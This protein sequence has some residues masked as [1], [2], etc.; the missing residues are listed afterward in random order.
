[1]AT[2]NQDWYDLN[3]GRSYPVADDATLIDSAGGRLPNHIICDLHILFPEL[4]GEYAY[5]GAVTVSSNLVSVIVMASPG[6]AGRSTVALAAVNLTKPITKY[7]HYPL[8][9]L[10]PGVGG[11]I[12]FGEG[13][14]ENYQG[15]FGR[16]SQSRLVE[17]TARKYPE[18]PIPNVGKA[19]NNSPLTGLVLLEAGND[20]EI[21][22]EC[23]EIPAHPVP[24]HSSY[25]CGGDELGTQVRDVI[26]FRLR[27]N[28]AEEENVFNKYK[29]RCGARPE[30]LSCG[31]PQPIQFLGPVSPD[32]CGNI[33]LELRGCMLASRVT[34]EDTDVACGVVVDCD[35]DIDEACVTAKYLPEEDGK[36][37][38]EYDDLCA[39]VSEIVEAPEGDF[40][41]L[42]DS[43][44]YTGAT[45]DLADR[46]LDGYGYPFG[47]AGGGEEWASTVPSNYQEHANDYV[48]VTGGPAVGVPAL[49]DFDIPNAS[50]VVSMTFG[51]LLFQNT[52]IGTPI[53]LDN[54]N[55]LKGTVTRL[56]V[57]T[58]V[59]QLWKLT[60]GV[61]AQIGG[62]TLLP[63]ELDNSNVYRLTTFYD[64]VNARIR[65]YEV[66]VGQADRLIESK[67]SVHG[68]D[69]TTYNKA[70]IYGWTAGALLVVR[71]HSFYA[72]LHEA[73]LDAQPIAA[74]PTLPKS[75]AIVG[76]WAI[77]Q[78]QF[79]WNA[80][81]FTSSSLAMTNLA[82]FEPAVPPVGT[83]GR[84]AETEFQILEGDAG[85]KHH[86]GVVINYRETSVGSGVY[87]FWLVDVDWD[88]IFT[89]FKSFRVARFT[90][91]QWITE[92]AVAV[93]GLALDNRYRLTV[94]VEQSDDGA[95]W[96]TGQL[97]GIDGPALDISIGPVRLTQY[98][99]DDDLFGI[100][101]QQ[102]ATEFQTFVV[103]NL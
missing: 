102:S 2:R 4:A 73:S 1:M 16:A 11:W 98:L 45:S 24:S 52:Y 20:M 94:S 69:L 27:S 38:T 72:G 41:W 65:L 91:Y 9:A 53:A 31:D 83:I 101:A 90:G 95:V 42:S 19:G 64:S 3:T 32:C 88:G 50:V 13:I 74:D 86:A 78:G 36:L 99:P 18:L 82:T 26:V 49:V 70:G 89:G 17:K 33:N 22:S 54:D 57:G 39:S 5:L 100:I 62:D 59:L 80:G 77:Q 28:T 25:Y 85:D 87:Q 79:T 51:T 97:E 6:V 75:P 71:V 103:D 29:G 8:E 63:E 61:W 60:A 46:I 58:D 84:F 81:V 67:D 76:D 30:S 12:V 21:V 43:F 96:V 15:R 68:V 44:Q 34:R 55:F 37:P 23:R 10:Y 48:E 47:E 56:T 92:Q 66:V 14:D 40:V 35:L 7:R 93:P